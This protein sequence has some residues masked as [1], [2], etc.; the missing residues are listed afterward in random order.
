MVG[1]M[2]VNLCSSTQHAVATLSS[3]TE[4]NARGAADALGL[5]AVL[6]ELGW[7]PAAKLMGC[8][9]EL[10]RQRHIEVKLLWVQEA[11]RRRRFRIIK[12]PGTTSPPRTS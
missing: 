8:R 1:G 10:G 12:I 3:E 7:E 9:R 5:E 6:G 2:L 4:Y 11:V